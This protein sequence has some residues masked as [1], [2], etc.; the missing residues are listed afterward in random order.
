LAA[1]AAFALRARREPASVAGRREPIDAAAGLVG[2]QVE[3]PVGADLDVADTAELALQQA[4]LAGHAAAVEV[5]P[6]QELRPQRADQD[7]AA[8]F[9]KPVAVVDDE[10]GRRDRRIPVVDRLLEPRRRRAD[11]DLAAGIVPAIA[12]RRPA[13][14]LAGLGKIDLVAAARAVLDGDEA[15]APVE[16]GALNVAM[17]D[18]IDLGT[19][20][21]AVRERV[22]G[23]A[24]SWCM[25]CWSFSVS[26]SNAQPPLRRR[27]ELVPSVPDSA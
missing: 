21:I 12:D 24:F 10:T 15:A 22:V 19:R 4:L 17:A 14:I 2:Q 9:G 7:I 25:S 26:Y 6:R 5:E 20:P 8:P 1:T 27:T 18:R 3:G 11:A 13:V 23:W 16:A